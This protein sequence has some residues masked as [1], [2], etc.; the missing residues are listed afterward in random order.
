MPSTPVV[1]ILIATMV[2]AWWALHAAMTAIVDNFGLLWGLI[3][4][5]GIYGTSL[6]MDRFD[7]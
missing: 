5:A 3:A 6:I 2:G 7:R 4:V 1:F